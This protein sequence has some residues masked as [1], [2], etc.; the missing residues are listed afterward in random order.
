MPIFDQG[1]Q[2]WKGE[3]SGHA[4]RWLTIT[5][6]G[7]RASFKNRGTWMMLLTGLVPA[8]ALATAVS[9]WGLLEQKSSLVTPFL[10][11]LDI[12]PE[13]VKAGPQNFRVAIWTICYQFFFGV[14]MIISMLLVVFVGPRLVSQDLRFNAMPLYFSRP[15]RRF[16]YFLGK[17]GV[18]AAFLSLVAIVPSIVAWILGAAFS[19]DLSVIRDTFP[20][21]LGAVAYG[22]VIVLSA[23]TLMLAI[24][25]LSRNSRYVGAMWIGI[26]IVPAIMGVLLFQAIEKPWCLTLSYTTNLERMGNEL[27]GTRSAWE[28]FAKVVVTDVSIS[29]NTYHGPH[30]PPVRVARRSEAEVA[31]AREE[32]IAERSLTIYPW[33]Y[34]GA[35]L[36]GLFGLSV[37]ILSTRVKS[38]DRLR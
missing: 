6:Q 23:G 33:Y 19:L 13:E 8:L 11:I 27:L 10:G 38:M 35:V 20:V 26:W 3:L 21:M 34:S 37:W 14:V 1:Y 2:H 16:D 17:L 36:L 31:A 12:F 32:F 9:L 15:L 4:W 7:V 29:P 30:A 25:S 5:K 22:V 18:I 28:K 24:S